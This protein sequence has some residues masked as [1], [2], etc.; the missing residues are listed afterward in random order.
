MSTLKHLVIA[1]IGL[2]G[3]RHAEVIRQHPQARLIA[4]VDP[5]DEAQKIARSF[6]LPCYPTLDAMFAKHTPDGVI[7]STPTP[8][9][10]AGAMACVERGC[11]VMV[12]KPIAT[13]TD[14]A[15]DLVAFAEDK[16]VPLLV[17]HH[18][19]HNPLVQ[20]A[21]QIIDNGDI[22]QIRAIHSQCWFYKPDSYFETAPWRTKIGAGPISVNLVHDVDF[23][24]YICGEVASVQAQ[25][26][27]SQRGFE[28]ED[29][30]A[31]I[32]RFTNGVIG[33]ITVSDSIAAP[34]SWELTSG[35]YPIY[36]KTTQ[37]CYM[38]GGSAGSL[39]VPDLTLWRHAEQPDWW[40]PINTTKTAYH[41][42]D[43]LVNQ[44]GHFIEVIDGR[45]KPLVSGREAL[46]TLRVVEAIQQSARD[47]EAVVL[48]SSSV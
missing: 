38:I 47:Q 36:P 34:W 7:L 48:D 16:N 10:V 23:I 12:E 40:S 32:L 26:T 33:T 5:S 42:A 21:K 19:R 8:L 22:G 35:E 31:A 2:V 6:D 13:S 9:H 15:K 3:K 24:R 18:R 45:V 39:S 46:A 44:I 1:G 14:D 25:A 17:G 20:K 43:P 37:S 11:P 4:I 29:V 27:P 28:N 41:A 30:A